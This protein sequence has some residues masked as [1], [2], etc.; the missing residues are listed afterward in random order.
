M[1]D[2]DKSLPTLAAELY[3]M[4]REY[5]KQ[6]TV[7]PIK[8]LGRFIA[9]GVAGSVLLGIGLVLLALGILRALQTETEDW[10]DGRLTFVPYLITFVFCALVAFVFGLRKIR[11]GDR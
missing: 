9:F 4:V 3:S 1:P 10:F 5:A 6:E 8:G 7:E 11:K 2:N